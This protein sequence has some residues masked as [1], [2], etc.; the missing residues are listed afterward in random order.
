MYLLTNWTIWPTIKHKFLCAGCIHAPTQAIE[1]GKSCNRK[2]GPNLAFLH[3]HTSTHISLISLCCCR[4]R[5]DSISRVF[6]LEMMDFISTSTVFW[7]FILSVLC[8]NFFFHL[9]LFLAVFCFFFRSLIDDQQSVC[10]S[11][12]KDWESKICPQIDEQV[13]FNLVNSKKNLKKLRQ[14]FCK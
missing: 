8:A 4:N 5:R 3:T 14:N 7:V 6:P 2:I 13:D 10:H 1:C 9:L 12:Y 11:C